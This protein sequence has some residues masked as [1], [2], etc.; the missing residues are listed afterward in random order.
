[1][2]GKE[3][4]GWLGEPSDYH[5]LE[6]KSPHC[7]RVPQSRSCV[8]GLS[9]RARPRALAAVGPAC[10]VAGPA[11]QDAPGGRFSPEGGHLHGSLW[12]PQPS[13]EPPQTSLGTPGV[14]QGGK[15]VQGCGLS[16]PLSVPATRALAPGLCAAPL[17]PEG[18]CCTAV[19]T[20]NETRRCFAPN[21]PVLGAKAHARWTSDL[22]C[23]QVTWRAFKNTDD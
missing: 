16:W 2:E 12:G 20:G 17:L 4:S 23:L 21:C 8:A 14:R 19:G 6:R 10:A 3:Q 1:M 11:T 9:R 15:S 5:A 22:G 18:R 7:D 13:L